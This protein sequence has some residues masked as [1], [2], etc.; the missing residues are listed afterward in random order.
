[1]TLAAKINLHKK[2]RTLDFSCGKPIITPQVLKVKPSTDFGRG[3]YFWRV[4]TLGD[5]R[6]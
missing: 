3:L 2:D 5:C 6:K 4:F 1:M